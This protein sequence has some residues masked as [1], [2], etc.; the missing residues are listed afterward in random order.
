MVE[1]CQNFQFLKTKQSI[2]FL[3]NNRALSNFLCEILIH[4]VLQNYKK[5]ILEIPILY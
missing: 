5:I 4:L 3:E 1:S 2:W